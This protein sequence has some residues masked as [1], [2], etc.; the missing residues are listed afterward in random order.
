MPS[1]SDLELELTRLIIDVLMLEDV[2]PDEIDPEAPLFNEGLGLD[3]IDSLDLGMALE[4]RYGIKPSEDGDE[5][6]SRFGSVRSLARFIVERR[7]K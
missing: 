5:N 2:V 1:P 7:T 4:E 6:A 3:S